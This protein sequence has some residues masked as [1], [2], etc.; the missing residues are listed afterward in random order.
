MNRLLIY[1]MNIL[2]NK[3]I[4]V[5]LLTST[6]MCLSAQ[7]KQIDKDFE[8]QF[9][10]EGKDV[11]W[12]PT[13]RIVVGKMLDIANVTSKDFVIDLGSGDGRIVIAAA[14][15]GARAKGIEYNPDMVELSKKN[16]ANEGI[17]DRAEFI[18]ADLFEADLS[19]ATVITMYLLPRINLRLRPRLLELK[20]GTRI[21]SNSHTMGDWIPDETALDI[22]DGDSYWKAY[23]WIIPAKVEGTWNTSK[24]KLE[25]SQRFQM[26]SGTLKT[27]KN[28]I[29]ISEGRL[30]GD[31]ITF[32]ANGEKFSGRVNGN[33]IKGTVTSG[34][35]NSQW[36]AKRTGN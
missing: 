18:Q 23:L 24:G 36:N 25:L 3:Y 9:G 13:P 30:Y 12:E 15:R 17:I 32:S 31:E 21:V 6:F 8:P 16:A 34:D 7:E 4:T 27:G 26:V 14:K 19:Q 2:T 5:L 35:N 20:P 28:T 22:K 33:S 29:T 10:Q 1:L 11:V